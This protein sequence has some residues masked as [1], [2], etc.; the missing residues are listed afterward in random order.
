MTTI[1]T[2]QIIYLS[3]KLTM[4]VKTSK[5]VVFLHFFLNNAANIDI[6]IIVNN[7][8]FYVNLDLNVFF[9]N[10]VLIRLIVKIV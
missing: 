5:L 8:K 1:F 6:P 10:F 2:I 9:L 7:K 3:I 4:I